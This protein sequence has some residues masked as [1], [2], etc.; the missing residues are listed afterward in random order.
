MSN[1]YIKATDKT[2]EVE[3]DF[4]NN[5]FS[6]IGRSIPENAIEFY[7]PTINLLKECS[8]ETTSK[9]PFTV[10][11]HF[12]YFNTSSSKCLLDILMILETISH[13]LPI[14]IDWYYEE[15]DVDILEAGED[16]LTVCK[17]PFRLI[18]I[19]AN[20]NNRISL[21]KYNEAKKIIDE[22]YKITKTKEIHDKFYT[23]GTHL[24]SENMPI[25][26]KGCF[27][28]LLNNWGGNK[29]LYHNIGIACHSSS[30]HNEAAQFLQKALE[31]DLN[32][33]SILNELAIV[34]SKLK[35]KAMAFKYANN[36]KQI[37]QNPETWFQMGK[38]FYGYTHEKNAVNTIIAIDCYLRALEM[39]SDYTYAHFHIAECYFDIEEYQNAEKHFNSCLNDYEYKET[40]LSYL[41]KTYH[42]LKEYKKAY[43][44][45]KKLIE[46]DS[47]NSEYFSDH[48]FYCLLTGKLSEA[49]KSAHNSLDLSPN[50]KLAYSFVACANL[51]MDRFN[52]AEAIYVKWKDIR[53]ANQNELAKHYFLQDINELQEAG[54][55]HPD[56]KKVIEIINE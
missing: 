56:F 12:E 45:S 25:T 44:V 2:P 5:R 30:D 51:L 33:I 34:Y 3:I 29:D 19:E 7:I 48:S 53:F 26:A 13:V 36:A 11:M 50:D 52:K 35:D 40:V 31:Y 22:E 8:E 16:Y 14:N 20:V 9:E 28:K 55:K 42:K 27:I 47:E 43:E 18:A 21:D 6:I 32:D 24:L 49:I 10:V 46:I 39:K 17:V 15:G 4:D 38:A 1:L 54:I 37:K 23:I 41:K